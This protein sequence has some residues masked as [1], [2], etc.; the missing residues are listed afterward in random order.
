MQERKEAV[1]VRIQ[2]IYDDSKQ[3]YGAPKIAKELQKMVRLS[4]SVQLANI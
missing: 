1:K 2:D 3:N 4:L